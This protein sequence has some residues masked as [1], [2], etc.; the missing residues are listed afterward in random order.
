MRI[1]YKV[2]NLVNKKKYGPFRFYRT[3]H[4]VANKIDDKYGKV[5]A[6][7]DSYI[8]GDLYKIPRVK[9]Q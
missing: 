4:I 5:V 9:H 8:N 6:E 1:Q 3:A 2:T 7:I